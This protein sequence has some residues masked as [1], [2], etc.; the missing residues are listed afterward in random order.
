MKTSQTCT[1]LESCL[2]V[3]LFR[4][5]SNCILTQIVLMSIYCISN[6]RNQHETYYCHRSFPSR[7]H[8]SR[9]WTE[10]LPPLHSQLAALRNGWPVRRGAFCLP[11][12]R[13]DIS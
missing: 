5:I 7:I 10:W 12:S 9:L 13:P 3:V 6:N 8:L 2:G 4:L 11:L 1:P